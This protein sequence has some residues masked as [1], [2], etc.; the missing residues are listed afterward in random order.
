[1]DENTPALA[2]ITKIIPD[3]IKDS[4]IHIRPF[5]NLIV[6]RPEDAKGWPRLEVPCVHDEG[7]T[8]SKTHRYSLFGEYDDLEP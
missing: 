8:I 5:V 4:G 6:F 2:F 3:S 1:M 7:G